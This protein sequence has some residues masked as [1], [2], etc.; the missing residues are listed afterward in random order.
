MTWSKGVGGVGGGELC[1]NKGE[2]GLCWGNGRGKCGM[3][4]GMGGGRTSDLLSWACVPGWVQV[5]CDYLD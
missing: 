5:V 2:G 1:C 4:C 3:G